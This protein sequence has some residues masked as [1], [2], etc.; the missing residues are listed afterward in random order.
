MTK[1]SFFS[2]KSCAV[3][4]RYLHQSENKKNKIELSI[5]QR[6]LPSSEDLGSNAIIGNVYGGFM[7]QSIYLLLYS[8]LERRNEE[9]RGRKYHID[10][11]TM[12]VMRHVPTE[13]QYLRRQKLLLF[14]KMVFYHFVEFRISV[15]IPSTKNARFWF[16]RNY[17]SLDSH[18]LQILTKL[19]RRRSTLPRLFFLR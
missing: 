15:N 19:Y 12:R 1:R 16:Q 11:S 9:K 5:W 14:A 2:R 4:G 7:H 3:I 6:L 17:P 13:L 8:S 18:T 10:I